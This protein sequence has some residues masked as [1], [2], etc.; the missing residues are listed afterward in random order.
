MSG[1]TSPRRRVTVANPS[2]N[3]N[4]PAVRFGA[5]AATGDF[6]IDTGSSTCVRGALLAANSSCGIDLTFTPTALGP[7][8]GTLTIND[9]AGNG[10]QIVTLNGT[11]IAGALHHAPGALQFGKVVLGMDKGISLTLK[12]PNHAPLRVTA[13][14]SGLSDY[15]T[16]AGCVGVLPARG[17]CS[18]MVN[19]APSSAGSKHTTLFIEDDAAHSPQIVKVAGTGTMPVLSRSP[20]SL[21]FGRAHLGGTPVA[22][23]VRL[24]NR[25]P[26]AIQVAAITSNNQDFVAAPACVGIL[27][28]GQICTFAVTFA[29]H[30]AGIS[31]GKLG[32]I[33]NAAQSPQLVTMSGIGMPAQSRR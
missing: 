1:A 12:N 27:Q 13:V 15:R 19:F 21:S 8:T 9:N 3:R 7:R 6:A 30:G 14:R 18:L 2:A 24:T 31:R 25:S 29:P 16:G 11:G 10:P 32:I 22:R 5:I 17:S 4:L 20:S 33:D 23:S 28:P 26:V